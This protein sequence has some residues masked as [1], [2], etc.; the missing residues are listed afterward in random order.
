MEQVFLPIK[1]KIAAWWIIV[2]GIVYSG[3]MFSDMYHFHKIPEILE[4][5]YPP[6]FIGIGAIILLVLFYSL[7]GLFLIKKKKAAWYLAI[8]AFSY[9]LAGFLF[10][11]LTTISQGS[12]ISLYQLYLIFNFLL[13]LI[14]VILLFLDRKNFFK[15]AS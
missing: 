10:R 13:M 5:G 8:T 12:L 15:I 14:P 6:L 7:I 9:F 3:Y 2:Y 1:T 11:L 4:E